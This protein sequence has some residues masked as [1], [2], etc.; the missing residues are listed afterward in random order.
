MSET[1]PAVD[2]DGEIGRPA[3]GVPPEREQLGRELGAR[4][5]QVGDLCNER[6]REIMRLGADDPLPA[7]NAAESSTL[8]TVI[9]ARWLETGEAATEHEAS[10]L[11][12][13][14]S[15]AT[16][17][18]TSMA[19]LVKLFLY[20]RD[21]TVRVLREIASELGTPPE[22]VR[23]AVAATRASCDASLVRMTRR[24]DERRVQLEAL[25]AEERG[26][27]LHEATHDQL[28]GLA[29]RKTFL[30]MVQAASEQL[31]PEE[32]FAVMFLD[33]DDFKE[34]NDTHGHVFGDLFLQ[35][36]ASRLSSVLRPHDTAGRVGGDEFV[37]LCRRLPAGSDVAAAIAQR[38]CEHLAAPVGVEGLSINCSVSIGLVSADGPIDASELLARADR[39]LYEAKRS[40]KARVAVV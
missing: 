29:N 24:F 23:V 5:E 36:V 9:L 19:T 37:V 39:A 31:A 1:A 17:G 8:A 32:G 12:R 26:R 16:S 20:W 10:V 3:P 28:T 22:I 34:V 40:G 30:Q 18:D 21:A 2:R 25:L 33:L 35:T 38:V 14:G 4:A 7:V 27:L 11:A 6:L 13:P 15:L